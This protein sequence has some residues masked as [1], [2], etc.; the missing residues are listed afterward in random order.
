MDK[1]VESAEGESDDDSEAVHDHAGDLEVSGHSLTS[2]RVCGLQGVEPRTRG[3]MI[4]SFGRLSL[5]ANMLCRRR[6]RR[7]RPSA[8]HGPI[9]SFRIDY[10][11]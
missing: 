2:L 3:I 7:I 10:H 11:A 9:S 1:A 4:D 6:S 5:S 8:E